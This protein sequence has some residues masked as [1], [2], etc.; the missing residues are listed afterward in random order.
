MTQVVKNP[1]AKISLKK[2]FTNNAGDPGSIPRLG[3]CPGEGKSYQL[4]YSG[5]EKSMNYIVDVVAKSQ[6]RL[7][8]FHIFGLP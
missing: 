7:R 3:R 8:D 2:E 5:L 6:T 4:H 1:P